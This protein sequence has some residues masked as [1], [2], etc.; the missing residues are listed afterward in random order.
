MQKLWQKLDDIDQA[1]DDVD[2]EGDA[3]TV[4]PVF[5]KTCAK[6]T[7]QEREKFVMNLQ[8]LGKQSTWK[9]YK[10]RWKWM[11]VCFE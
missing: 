4:P 11:E 1:P 6:L 8:E 5:Q 3:N 7:P 2:T 10:A 9:Q